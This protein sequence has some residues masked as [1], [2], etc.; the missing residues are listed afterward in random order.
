MFIDNT[1]YPDKLEAKIIMSA[2]K[3]ILNLTECAEI[4]TVQGGYE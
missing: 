4:L 1:I 3:P 2:I